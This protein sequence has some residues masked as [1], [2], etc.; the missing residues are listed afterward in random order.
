MKYWHITIIV[1]VFLT[2]FT[3]NAF[4]ANVISRLSGSQ[5]AL[6]LLSFFVLLIFISNALLNLLSFKWILKPALMLI[7]LASAAAAYFMDEFSTM[8][9]KEMLINVFE[10]DFR[11][12][13]EFFNL[14]FA[15]KLLLLGVIPAYLIYRLPVIYPSSLWQG[16]WQR[17][18]I[19]VLS[20][21]TAVLIILSQYQDFSGFGR[22]NR[23]L[24][25]FINPENYLFSLKSLAVEALDRGGIVAKP[26]A[27]DASLKRSLQQRDKP[28]LVV[29]VVGETARAANFSLNGYAKP[30]NPELMKEAVVSFSNTFSCG[31]ATAIS[32]PCMFSHLTRQQYSDKKVR[33]FQRLPDVVQQAGINVLW[34]ENNTGCKGNC[35][36]IPTHQLANEEHPEFCQG[37]HCFDEILLEGID[38]YLEQKE[39]DQLL[40]LHQKGNH[41][42]AYYLRYPPVFDRFKP[43]CKTNQLSQCTQEEITNAY[44]NA[45]LYTDYLLAKTIRMLQAKSEQYHTVMIYVSDHGESLGENN[46]YLHGMPY[47]LAPDTQKHIPFIV[48]LSQGYQQSYQTD[49]NCLLEKKSTALTHDNLFSSIL[50][51]FEIQT[52]IYDPKLDLFANCR[53]KV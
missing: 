28:T 18:L 3:N 32:L 35:D 11:E 14:A 45:L 37:G 52:E 10:S 12:S 7:I 4:W 9:D 22:V 40:I 44:D 33:S 39:G 46:L 50:G 21:S 41:G 42:P 1:S 43:A 20:L 13:S 23:D 47:L 17:S 27:T 16:L 48:W 6:F 25:H 5:D 36:R 29:L 34:R 53:S 2:A 15:V 8:I 31:T 51:L 26:I 24:R 30:T 38:D 19:L 49:Q